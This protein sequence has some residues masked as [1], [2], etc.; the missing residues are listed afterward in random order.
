MPMLEL[1]RRAMSNAPTGRNDG[2]SRSLSTIGDGKSNRDKRLGIA[3]EPIVVAP[4]RAPPP[5]FDDFA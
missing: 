1:A 4:A 2:R 3:T 5:A